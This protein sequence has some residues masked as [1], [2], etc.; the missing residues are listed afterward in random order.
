MRKPSSVPSALTATSMSWNQR[1][2][3]CDIDW[4]KS[5]RHSVHC[6]GRFE[7]A[8][9]QAAGDELRVRGDLVAEAAAD[10][11]R[12]EAQLVDADAAAPA[13]S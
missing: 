12:D 3:P 11:L 13:P 4:W 10:V 5:V 1:S 6:T 9:E 7:L 8:R 2:L